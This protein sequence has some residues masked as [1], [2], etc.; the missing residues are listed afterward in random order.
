M[1]KEET[2]FCRDTFSCLNYC[3]AVVCGYEPTCFGCY[4]HMKC[5][6]CGN[7]DVCNLPQAIEWRDSDCADD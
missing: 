4:M 2:R 7:V 3:D 6:Y 1:D 5:A